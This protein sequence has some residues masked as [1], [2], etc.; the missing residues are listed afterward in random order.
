MHRFAQELRHAARGLLR[1]PLFTAGVIV[2]L[3][4]GIGV[5]ATMFGVVDTLFMRAPAGVTDADQIVRVYYR[6][7]F[8]GMGTFTQPTTS[9]PTFTA[10]RD[11]VPGFAYTA[12]MSV[13]H[14]SLGLGADAMR[15]RTA[16]VSH[17]YFPMLGVQPARGRFFTATED[18]PGG[19]H[20]AV[21]TH[22]FW[23][24]HFGGDPAIVGRPLTLGK[25]VYTVIGVGPA[26]FS[27]IELEGVDLF[28]PIAVAGNEAQGQQVL[29]NRGWFWL[30]VVARL[31]PNLSRAT[32]VAQATA[33]LRQNNSTAR[34]SDST[35]RVV[36][37]PIQEARGPETSDDAKV[38]AWIGAVSLIVLL[39]A[40]ANI[41]N[42]LLARGMGRQREF[43]V[44][45]SL[46]AGRGGLIWMVLMES[47]LLAISGGAIAVLFALWG[48]A[49]ART[50]LIP[51]LANDVPLV[52][53]RVLMVAGVAVAV[54]ALLIGLVPAIQA[55]RTDLVAALKAGGRGGTT[56]HGQARSAL[57]VAQVAL[58][59]ALLVGAGLFVRSLRN[60][61]AVDL[62]L[63]VD[64][65]V[66]MSID[67]DAGGF[68]P[69]E[70]TAAWLRV[71]DRVQRLPG[72]ESAAISMGTPFFGY[73]YSERLR[74]EGPDTLPTSTSGGPYYQVVSPDYM[75]TSGTRM[76]AG[77][78]FTTGDVPGSGDVAI[79]GATFAKLVWPREAAVGK[80]LYVGDS[81]A[82]CRR[83]VGVAADGRSS[84]I[85]ESEGLVYY[86]PFAQ[87]DKPRVNAMFVRARGKMSL[88][89][90]AL[91]REVH[92]MG[93]L[94]YAQIEPMADKVA[95]ELR[96]WRLGSAAFSA[97]G[98][99]A[100]VIAATGIFAV[101]SYAVSQRTQE[102]GVRVALGAQSHQV[103]EMVVAQALRITAIGIA[104][105]TVGAFVL[106]RF[107][108]S[109]LYG[110][111]AAD[112]VVFTTTM[113][114]L[115]IVAGGAAYLPARRAAKVDPMVALRHE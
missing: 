26:G 5:N 11:R 36:L 64:R 109:L 56:R 31:R 50:F 86:L 46:G 65:I 40:C 33:A 16:T 35:S 77:R 13:R 67:F 91:R 89:I 3:A 106:G 108:A 37:G 43:A 30:Q 53:G 105:G 15:V 115:L 18:R 103:V 1:T 6:Q 34:R 38:S 110:V 45:A 80:C 51:S 82:T 85:R 94:P 96:S 19:E 114:V 32:I 98:L 72:V 70:A 60:A 84:G 25:S 74:V 111:P 22:G 58:T 4:L 66:A 59:M 8:A 100:L 90:A 63:D 83:I 29:D 93:N 2:T 113:I 107:I 21:L 92:A 42:L 54:T 39:I 79:V 49:A 112:V 97:F 12:A 61:Q 24:R 14:T 17:Q 23:Q 28:L 7:T 52:N 57:L 10:M 78:A 81:T 55:T 73:A 75:A 102:V 62:G 95:P 87:A 104:V 44:R 99:L 41:A 20:V 68:S 27:G 88:L 9:Y 47:L 48:G 76:V 101:L 71:L 69:T